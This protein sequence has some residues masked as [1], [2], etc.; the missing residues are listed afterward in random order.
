M[1]GLWEHWQ[2]QGGAEIE[3]CTLLTTASHGVVA[4]IHHRMPVILS[5]DNYRQWM[6]AAE[7]DPGQVLPY[8]GAT[9]FDRLASFPVN[10]LVN[11]PRNDVPACI[12][13][14]PSEGEF[15]PAI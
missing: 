9:P 4:Q 10:T 1:A 12:E 6:D 11:N 14:Q 7:T 8:L 2:G 3:S 5:R 15:F 13:P